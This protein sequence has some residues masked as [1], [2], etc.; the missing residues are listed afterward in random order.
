M[1]AKSV[2]LPQGHDTS[3]S[4]PAGTN[5]PA[6][7]AAR[8]TVF[9]D[10][11]NTQMEQRTEAVDLIETLVNNIEAVISGNPNW[12]AIKDDCFVLI[13]DF[14]TSIPASNIHYEELISKSKKNQHYTNLIW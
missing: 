12:D 5:N 3:V 4:H 8:V 1:A 6:N 7:N 13:N 10:K 2:S 11:C 14:P 9:T